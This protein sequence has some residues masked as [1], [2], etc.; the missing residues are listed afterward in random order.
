ML[1]RV[2]VRVLLRRV[3]VVVVVQRMIVMMILRLVV[4]VIPVLVIVVVLVLVIG[5]VLAVVLQ[6]VL[7]LALLLAVA[8]VVQ[9]VVVV[10]PLP[11]VVVVLLLLVLLSVVVSMERPADGQEVQGRLVY[12]SVHPLPQREGPSSR[13]LQHVV[14]LLLI[15]LLLLRQGKLVV[16]LL[17][18]HSQALRLPR[19]RLVPG[20][21]QARAAKFLVVRLSL[22]RNGV[23]VG[24]HALSP[25]KEECLHLVKRAPALRNRL[26]S[27]KDAVESPARR[28]LA[29]LLV[30]RVLGLQA[31]RLHVVNMRKCRLSMVPQA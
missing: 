2:L 27:T 15:L 13:R 3:L 5:M 17:L 7:V 4:G 14:L 6:V 25:V 28:V 23:G 8:A 31:A 12:L 22:D 16:L 21:S 18:L 24:V 29:L 1:V 19:D 10:L 11:L 20:G 26:L 9:M 30:Q